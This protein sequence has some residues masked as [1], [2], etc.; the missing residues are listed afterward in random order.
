M[1]TVSKIT[2]IDYLKTQ[3]QVYCECPFC[4][5]IFRLNEARLTFGKEARKDLLDRLRKMREDFDERLQG[6]RE[7]AKRRSRAVSKGLMLESICPYLPD[8]KYH[9][10]DAR[11][12]GDP[13]DFVIF[14]GLY[15]GKKVKELTIL[16]VKSGSS[17]MNETEMSIKKAVE[18]GKVN[19]ELIQLK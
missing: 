2:L 4:K 12:L 10:R 16:E 15:P 18:K 19:F 5:E 14:D 3:S 9:P 11:F 1:K 17:K 8:F 13:I 7:D 6:E